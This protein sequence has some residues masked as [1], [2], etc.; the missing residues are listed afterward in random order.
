MRATILQTPEAGRLEVLEDQVVTVGEDGVITS[1]EPASSSDLAGVQE[2][3][4]QVV[5]IPGLIDTHVHAPQWPQLYTGLDLPLDEWLLRYTFPLEARCADLDY[6]RGVWDDLVP[7]LLSYGTTTAVYYGSTHEP[8]TVALAEACVRHGQR[9]FVGRVAMDHPEGTPDYYRD[10]SASEAVE[11]SL[12]SVEAIRALPGATGLVAP[13]ITPRFIPACTDAA[14]EGLGELAEATGALVQTHVSEGD[15]EHGYVLERHGMTDTRSL[16]RFGLIRDH[17]VLAHGVHIT[18]DDR[19]R[20]VEAG[21]GVAHCPLSNAYFADA[22]FP[23]RRHLDAGLRVGLGTD[24]AGGPEPSLLRQCAHA[25]TSSRMLS[26]GVDPVVAPSERGTA[27][28]RVDL[29]TAF[30]TATLGGAELLGIAAGLLAPGR[31]FDA[32]A[33]RLPSAPTHDDWPRIF[34]QIV[35]SASPTSID[36]VWV[37]GVRTRTVSDAP[38]ATA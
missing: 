18:A 20:L 1:I 29:L 11:A 27:G 37:N 14:L 7:A 24:I 15:W 36:A 38:P 30:W 9:A 3:D 13:I 2:L 22:V 16:D 31:V 21:A 32:V 10:G 23:L 28:S 19:S 5:L 35:R 8:A 17:A 25:V 12:R 4:E 6:A 26:D 33:M 34:E